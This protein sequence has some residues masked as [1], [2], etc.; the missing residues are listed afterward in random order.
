MKRSPLPEPD[1][2]QGVGPSNPSADTFIKAGKV[3][4]AHRCNV[5]WDMSGETKQGFGRPRF[6]H[7][8]A[9]NT[10]LVIEN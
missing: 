8:S 5:F 3:S 6:L 2:A 1:P 4:F 9:A 7:L 10:L